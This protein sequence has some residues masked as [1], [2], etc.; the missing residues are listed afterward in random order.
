[1]C[2]ENSFNNLEKNADFSIPNSGRIGK[3]R[4][5]RNRIYN[6]I[7]PHYGLAVQ[8]I[9]NIYLNRLCIKIY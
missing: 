6:N 5:I 2:Q 8:N 3:N 7:P 4:D 1:M 9:K